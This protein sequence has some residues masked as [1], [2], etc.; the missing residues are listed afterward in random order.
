MGKV[1]K[2]AA[3]AGKVEILDFPE[4]F[5][6]SWAAEQIGAEWAEIVRPRRL[7][8]GCVMIV[9]EEG[10][11]KDNAYGNTVASWLYAADEHGEVIV[12]DCLFMAEEQGPEGGELVGLDEQQAE[13]LKKEIDANVY[14]WATALFHALK[15]KGAML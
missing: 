12:G 11:L 4:D 3:R 10:K 5:T 7:F 6:L 14:A 15:A 8:D 9:D 13:A 2:V 1:V